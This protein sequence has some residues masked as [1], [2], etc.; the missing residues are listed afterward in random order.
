MKAATDPVVLF[1][2]QKKKAVCK[3]AGGFFFPPRL[4]RTSAPHSPSRA[5][6]TILAR[7]QQI[8]RMRQ[9]FLPVAVFF[10]VPDNASERYGKCCKV[11]RAVKVTASPVVLFCL[12]K[13]RGFCLL[14][15]SLPH[16]PPRAS[17]VLTG[18]RIFCRF[19]KCGR[20]L[21]IVI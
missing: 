9:R 6:Q 2:L 7:L 21:R 13:R 20:A 12:Q 10:A 11:Q 4:S 14:R 17:T 3:I 18:S 15:V 1:Y 16:E 19:G 5:A 8:R